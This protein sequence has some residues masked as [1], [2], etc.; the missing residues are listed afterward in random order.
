MHRKKSPCCHPSI[1]VR[2]R[3]AYAYLL[4]RLRRR[5]HRLRRSIHSHSRST[6]NLTPEAQTTL[7]GTDR[8]AKRSRAAQRLRSIPNRFRLNTSRS[9]GSRRSGSRRSSRRQ[10]ARVRHR[11]SCRRRRYCRSRRR[12]PECRTLWRVAGPVLAA[13]GAAR[14]ASARS[15]LV[16]RQV[17]RYK[18][19]GHVAG[20]D[21]HR[22]FVPRLGRDDARRPAEVEVAR[23]RR[24][25]GYGNSFRA[26]SIL[27]ATAAT[28]ACGRSMRMSADSVN[29]GL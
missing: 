22:L 15:H 5:A 20:G 25:G 14:R 24:R 29:I 10:Y 23:A 13:L 3:F 6:E 16:H 1:L 4:T 27:S 9:S 12:C 18:S 11:Q 2:H 7:R 19:H 17:C 21:V 8:P 28:L 26:F